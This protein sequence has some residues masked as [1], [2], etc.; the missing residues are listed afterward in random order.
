MVDTTLTA[1][2]NPNKK[3]DF[4]KASAANGKSVSEALNDLVDGY[5][6]N[7][8]KLA[9][10]GKYEVS[11]KVEKVEIIG[12]DDEE[13]EFAGE[14]VSGEVIKEIVKAV[15]K[16]LPNILPEYAK[17]RG[18]TLI[19]TETLHKL[20]KLLKLKKTKESE[21]WECPCGYKSNH[22]FDKCPECKKKIEWPKEEKKDED[23]EELEV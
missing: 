20:L 15:V 9:H 23:E 8:D 11:P 4:I 18:Y 5:L 14:P 16:E 6:N 21:P 1:K 13:F 17:E 22:K 10:P 12:P 7:H 2:V 19:K 3:A